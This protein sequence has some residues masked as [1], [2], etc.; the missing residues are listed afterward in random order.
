MKPTR[1]AA[2]LAAMSLSPA[3]ARAQQPAPVG[4][5]AMQPD[6]TIV[7][8]LRTGGSGTEPR[9]HARLLYPP[10]HPQYGMILRH[11]GGLGPGETKPVPPFP[12]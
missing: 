1:R 10:G 3:D 9:G 6:G 8:D 12:R 11:L 2:L 7:L 5:A 4:I